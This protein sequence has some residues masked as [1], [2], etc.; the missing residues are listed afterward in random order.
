MKNT[1]PNIQ[2]AQRTQARQTQGKVSV[3]LKKITAKCIEKYEKQLRGQ[4]E[5][6]FISKGK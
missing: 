1:N 3:K 2:E 6:Q 5:G 4:G